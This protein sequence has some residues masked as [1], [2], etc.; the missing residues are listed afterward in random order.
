MERRSAPMAYL[1]WIAAELGSA[2]G[3]SEDTSYRKVAAPR[4]S[5]LLVG[6]AHPNRH[7]ALRERKLFAIPVC[8]ADR[9]RRRASRLSQCGLIYN[10]N[11]TFSNALQLD[12][13]LIFRIIARESLTRRFCRARRGVLNTPPNPSLLARSLDRSPA[14]G[15]P[16]I[17]SSDASP[18]TPTVA[19]A[20]CFD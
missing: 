12:S 8:L 3:F 7:N 20:S 2:T 15:Q 5:A 6:P 4:G 10:R 14:S 13:L 18:S 19:A 1:T 9:N 16:P 17:S 11:P